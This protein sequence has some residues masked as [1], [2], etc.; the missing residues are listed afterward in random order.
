MVCQ[1]FK[2]CNIY[3]L[4]QERDNVIDSIVILLDLNC[5][6][7][8]LRNIYDIKKNLFNIKSDDYYH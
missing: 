2:S 4:L 1:D 5:C 7:L 3:L 8:E 6:Q